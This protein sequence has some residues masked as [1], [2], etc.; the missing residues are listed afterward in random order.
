MKILLQ[1]GVDVLHKL[2]S[3]EKDNKFY[4]NSLLWE[5]NQT[6]INKGANS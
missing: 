2:S 6:K 5:D 3:G 4:I 1:G